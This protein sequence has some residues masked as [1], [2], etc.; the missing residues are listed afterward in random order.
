MSAAP[1]AARPRSNPEMPGT[2]PQA[3][4]AMKR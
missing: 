3:D 2:D 4:T 1:A